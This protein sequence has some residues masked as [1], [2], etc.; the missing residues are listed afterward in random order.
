MST[1]TVKPVESRREKK[2]FINLA[3]EIYAGDEMWCPPLLIDLKERAGFSKHPFHDI[4]ET[5]TFIALRDGKVVG[6]IQAIVNRG[7][8][9][10]YDEQL[11]FF[12]LFESIDDQEVAN[13]LFDTVRDWLAERDIHHMRGP[14]NPGLNYEVGLLIDGWHSPPCFMM[15]Y[16]PPYYP[17]LFENYGLAK[18]EDLVAFYAPTDIVDRLDP[19]MFRIVDIAKEKF[20]LKLRTLDTKRFKEDVR[21]FLDIYN[22]SLVGTWGFVPMSDEELEHIAKG[23]RLLI[24]PEL[25]TFIE[26]DGKVIGASVVLLDYNE[27]IKEIGGKLFPFGYKLFTKRRKITKMRLISANVL[28]EYQ[29]WGLGVVL[30]SRLK[31]LWKV[32]TAKHLE[33][34]WVL[35]SNHLSYKSLERAGCTVDKTYRI[36]DK[37]FVE[38]S[39]EG[40]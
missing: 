26:A 4:N 33:V 7:H 27:V 13:S 19:K 17:L 2:Q 15:T 22:K 24:V 6:R 37:V 8:I 38:P 40:E 28:P 36:Y 25:T 20:D 31:D 34:S 18:V 30:V 39:S 9:E 21:T 3:N 29:K 23:L 35:E 32:W 14:V 10:R 12:G 1:I 5:Q 16:N 11:G